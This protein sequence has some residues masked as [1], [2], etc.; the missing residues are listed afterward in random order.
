MN[1]EIGQYLK[2]LLPANFTPYQALRDEAIKHKIPIMES[3]SLHFLEVVLQ[4][5]QP[6]RILEIGTGVGYSALKMSKVCQSAN[7]ITLEND[8]KRAKQAKKNIAK[9][10]K[11]AN[12]EVVYCDALEFLKI[13]RV[14]TFDV[15]FIDAAKSKYKQFFELADP[16]LREKG[17]IVSDNVLFRGYVAGLKTP[18]KKYKRIVSN[19]QTYNKWLADHPHYKTTFI[20]IGDGVALSFKTDK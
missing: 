9:Y 12:I 8:C 17:L 5:V 3:T 19:L 15:I 11:T 10:N 13:K 18:P 7:I 2:E 4:I 20:P 1:E 6:Q 16:L 14:E